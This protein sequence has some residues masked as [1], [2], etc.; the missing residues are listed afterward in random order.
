[1]YRVQSITE[2]RW[3]IVDSNERLVFAGTKRQAKE[4]LDLQENLRR[5]PVGWGAWTQSVL[6]ALSRPISRLL[7]R[8]HLRKRLNCR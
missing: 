6:Q 2:D 4:W 1:M 8:F 7:A 3:E 5:R